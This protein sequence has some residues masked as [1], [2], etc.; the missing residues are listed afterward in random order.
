MPSE[1]VIDLLLGEG[2]TVGNLVA[3]SAFKNGV[4]NG[5]CGDAAACDRWSATETLGVGDDAR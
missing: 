3:V 2:V 4:G 1:S 5:G